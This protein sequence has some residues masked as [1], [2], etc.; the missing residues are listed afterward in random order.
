MEAIF[1]P[2]N[3]A[4]IGAS[5]KVGSIG[6]QVVQNLVDSKFIGQIFPINPTAPE[7]CGIKAYKSILD[8][9]AAEI[10]IAVYTVPEKAVLACAK[11]A[12]QKKVKGHV[13]ITSGFSE[14]GNVES[15]RELLRIAQSGGGR[16]VGPNIVGVLYNGCLANASFAPFL[17]YKVCVCTHTCACCSFLAVS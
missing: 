16:V 15:E 1:A 12:A 3:I 13:V 5:S 11:E 8:V 17:P 2:K 7:I 9:P 10:D 6:N 4:V 14:V